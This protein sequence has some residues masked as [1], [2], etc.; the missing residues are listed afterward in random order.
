MNPSRIIDLDLDIHFIMHTL[1]EYDWFVMFRDLYRY[2]ATKF[3]SAI[4]SLIT[5]K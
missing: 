3:T 5:C 2:L 4:Q 1:K